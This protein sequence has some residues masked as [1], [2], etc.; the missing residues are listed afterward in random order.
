MKI[1]FIGN[2][3]EFLGIEY[4]SAVL[5]NNNHSFESILDPFLFSDVFLKIDFLSKLFNFKKK[6][7]KKIEEYK[8]DLIVFSVMTDEYKWA[9]NI[10]KAI[11]QEIPIVLGGIHPTSVPE[12][13]LRN[14]F[15]DFVIVGEGEYAMLELV[16]ELEKD[17]PNFNIKNLY[18]KKGKK[19]IKN[20]IR[21]LINLNFLPFPDKEVYYSK[22]P[23]LKDEY[24][25]ITSRGC[26]YNCSYCC[27]NLYKKMYP[28]ENYL[29]RRNVNDV[30]LELLLVKRKYNPKL[31]YFVDDSFVY[32]KKWLRTFSKEYK[33]KI[34]LPFKC[35]SSPKYL[36]KE[37]ISILKYMG[38]TRV[39]VG[40][41]STS[42]KIRKD[43]CHRIESNEHIKE[44]IKFSKEER[45]P[46]HIDHMFGLPTQTTKDLINATKFYN[47]IKPEKI[48]FFWLKYYPKTD[49]INIA[50]K[51]GILNKS[52]INK[53]NNNNFGKEDTRR[54]GS[55]E[56]MP[57]YKEMKRFQGLLSLIP[58]V[59]KRV[60][61]F[62]LNKKLY[63]SISFSYSFVLIIPR[64]IT[65]IS[66]KDFR[67][68]TFLL[69][70]IYL[71]IYF[72]GINSH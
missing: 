35:F 65:A 46:I 26:P 14:S 64:M 16:N 66:N 17:K 21:P 11:K 55:A 30:I 27:N 3:Y 71:Y 23:C 49:I 54:G 63:K 48:N 15:V 72:V 28:N 7:I 34:N 56:N 22:I 10:A 25:I 45:V 13:V 69:L 38:C 42:E 60:I 5:R 62:M 44:I 9:C 24:R 32:S 4:I 8:P 57:D 37:V 47:E 50:I 33:N 36:D 41:Q 29:R 59:P 68:E 1:L 67:F 12:I 52:D 61:S 70:K 58:F 18:Y 43:I 20:E 40:L 6:V 39:Q 31:I 19:I 2:K 53:I 51:K